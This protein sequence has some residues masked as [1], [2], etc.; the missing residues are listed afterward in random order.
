MDDESS[1]QNIIDTLRSRVPGLSSSL[2]SGLAVFKGPTQT[3]VFVFQEPD[4]SV[5]IFRSNPHHLDKKVDFRFDSPLREAPA[6]LPSSWIPDEQEL[7][8]DIPAS[9]GAVP[10]ARLYEG[11]FL[12]FFKELGRRIIEQRTE[13]LP[14]ISASYV[15][16]ISFSRPSAI[17]IRALLADVLATEERR[18]P[19]RYYF[20]HTG[21]DRMAHFGRLPTGVVI[22]EVPQ[23][24]FWENIE[25]SWATPDVARIG[26]KVWKTTLAEVEVLAFSSGAVAADTSDPAEALNAINLLLA[27]LN[28]HGIRCTQITSSELGKIHVNGCGLAYAWSIQAHSNRQAHYGDSPIPEEIL[29]SAFRF[30]DDVNRDRKLAEVLKLHH[31]AWDHFVGGELLQAFIVQWTV[32]ERLLTRM[33]NRYLAEHVDNK[34]RREGLAENRDLT[35][36]LIVELLC[37]V[38]EIDEETHSESHA[39]RRIRNKV[40]HDGL[41]PDAE[42]ARRCAGLSTKFLSVELDLLR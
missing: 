8:E 30:A 28:V 20:A 1:I 33:W 3:A 38:G 29:Q 23:K 41:I 7:I 19:D 31:S 35:I 14:S 13:F 24:S 21:K 18:F 36:S 40:I 37:L 11:V 5:L 17:S 9:N 10:L 15:V 25:E 4:I 34:K 16:L 12:R 26:G 22:G 27:A 39:M 6:K 32:V 42:H 2:L